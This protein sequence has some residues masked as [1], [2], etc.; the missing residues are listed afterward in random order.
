MSPSQINQWHEETKHFPR[1]GKE[2]TA[3]GIVPDS[4]RIPLHPIQTA[5]DSPKSTQIYKELAKK[6]Q[7]LD[8]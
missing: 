3:T 6:R 4:H 7:N 8:K 5:W 2:I 1:N